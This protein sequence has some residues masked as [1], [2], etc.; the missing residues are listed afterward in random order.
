MDFSFS[1]VTVGIVVILLILLISWS[2]QWP[3]NI[4]PGPSGYPV[5][6]CMLMFRKGNPLDVF[7]KLRAQYG[8]V[9]SMR[10][11]V[12]LVVV[13]NG[14]A[15]LKEAFIRHGDEFSDRADNI[16]TQLVLQ[17]KGIGL[18][19]GEYWKKTRTFALSTLRNFG[20]GRKSLES[21]IQDEVAAYLDVI[22]ELNGQPHDLK[23]ITVLA[24]SNI[25]CS[26]TFGNRFEYNDTKFKRITSLFAE[27]FRLNTVGSAVRLFPFLRFLPGDMFNIKKLLQN[28][29]DI[30]AFV[31]EQITEH[32]STFE[33]DNQRDFIDAFLS[34]QNK[35]GKEDNIFEDLNVS[36][37]VR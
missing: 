16:I 17:N 9:Y 11:G 26:I 31:D 34:Q 7:R 29:R 15:T 21:R 19:S 13:I 5:V 33:E 10:N 2:L 27:N 12:N 25:I 30:K 35:Y 8:E 14:E 20:F 6:G 23:E 37:S 32:R 4:P 1:T 28:L 22:E 36:A 18:S 3:V 24:I